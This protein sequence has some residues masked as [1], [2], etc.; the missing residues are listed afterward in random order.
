MIGW[1]HERFVHRRRVERLGA[2][3]AALLPDGARAVDVGCGDGRI[4]RA[5]SER[6]PDVRMVG[7][8]VS[9]RPHT[10]IPVVEFDGIAIPFANDAFDVAILIDV[11]H[12]AVD[13]DALLA[14]ARRVASFGLVVKDHLLQG[15][16]AGPT[17]RF[18][19]RIGNARHG[20]D[21][22]FNYWP[23]ARWEEAFARLRLRTDRWD[24]RLGLYPFPAS[25]LFERSL[26]FLARARC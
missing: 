18:M 24:G 9:A 26:H 10:A 15:P 22:P 12:H 5:I 4:A 25:L 14:E 3:I 23:R 13:P 17:L 16:L 7:L 2:R 6:R 8:E 19:D 21:L 20:V 1:A 11:V